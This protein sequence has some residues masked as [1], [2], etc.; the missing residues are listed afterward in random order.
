MET[1]P[2]IWI[3]LGVA[4]VLL[5]LVI[6]GAVLGFIG[7]AAILTGILIYLGHLS[8]PV[9]IMMTF[10]VSSIFFILVLRTGLI[11]LFPSQSL[12]ENTDET[13]D[14]IGRI[15]DVIEPITPYRRGRIK[16]LDVS[17][18][19][20]ADIEIEAGHQ[21]VISGRDGNCWIVKSLN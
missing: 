16:Y 18:E 20:Q 7:G 6:P 2:L 14:A 9:D 10:F 13:K 12:V 5:E 8:G 1:L 19:A 21:A 17:W 15:V 11:K 3:G 4:L